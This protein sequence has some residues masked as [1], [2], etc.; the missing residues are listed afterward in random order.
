MTVKKHERKSAVTGEKG[1][2]GQ[3]A[4]ICMYFQMHQP[5]RVKPYKV[6]DVGKDHGY[7][8]GG[9]DQEADNGAIMA[10]VAQKSYIPGCELLLKL[11]KRHPEFRFSLS[12]SG[13]VLEQFEEF[14][15]EVI[16]LLK[17]L[18][19]TGN[20]EI[21]AETYYHS[22]SAVYHREEFR[23]Q[24]VLHSEK[25]E[26]LLGVKPTAFRNTE[27]IYNNEIAALA[28]E[29]G[30]KVILAEG[31]DEV[32]GSRSPNYVYAVEGLE[33]IRLLMKNYRLSDDVA[34]RFSDQNWNEWPLTVEKYVDWLSRQNG[35]V[36][37]LFMDFETLGEHQWEETGIFNFFDALP[38]ALIERGSRFMTVTEAGTTF[39]PQGAMHIPHYTSWADKGRDLSAWAD[40]PMQVSA[41]QA[42]FDLMDDVVATNDSDLLHDWRRLQASDHFYY[43]STKLYEDGDVH[44]Y[45]SP[46]ESPYDAFTNYMNVLHDVRYRISKLK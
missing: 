43:M 45:F 34:F 36:V 4:A 32:L 26:A 30:Y 33:K 41:I 12:V 35:D 42:V 1:E 27:L 22:L 40:N 21:L 23:S 39:D 13:L 44:A 38:E 24:I 28:E 9:R 37:N 11:I 15:P 16:E 25:V 46:Y 2:G 3:F 31:V 18:V 29:L 10:K 6:F 17:K 8:G 14:A 7:F 20:V 5:W 19:K